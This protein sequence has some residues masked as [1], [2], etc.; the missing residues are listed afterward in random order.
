MTRRS[1]S[2]TKELKTII[3][4]AA[5]AHCV[6]GMDVSIKELAQASELAIGSIYRVITTKA[7]LKNIIDEHCEAMF[8][9][10]V[11]AAIPAKLSL[12]DRFSLVLARI[13]QFAQTN[14][15]AA[16]YLAYNGFGQSS[17]MVK[18]CVGFAAEGHK[19]GLINQK[20]IEYAYPLIWGPI[21][22]IIKSERPSAED[23][24]V[25]DESIWAALTI[26]QA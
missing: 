8:N 16:N 9:A 2:T 7:D 19:S 23:L 21:S 5:I 6:H 4:S 17:L 14:T 10:H 26:N 12:R 20:I 18:S 22:A 25:I 3:A 1:P 13:F 11:F 15:Q 24:N